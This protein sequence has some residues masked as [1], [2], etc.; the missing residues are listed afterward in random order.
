MVRMVMKVLSPFVSIANGEV[1]FKSNSSR[2]HSKE[3][4]T[5]RVKGSHLQRCSSLFANELVQPL[6]HFIG[7]FVGECD[8]TYR[9]RKELVYKNQMSNSGGENLEC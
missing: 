2:V 7:S 8:S 9:G 5:Q 3:A 4:R 1:F 6:P